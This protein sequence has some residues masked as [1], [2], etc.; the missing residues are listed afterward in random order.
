[1][2]PAHPRLIVDYGLLAYIGAIADVSSHD[3][4]GTVVALG[5]EREFELTLPDRTGP[6]RAAVVPPSVPRSVDGGGATMAVC[7]VDPDLCVSMP[8][9]AG[10][11]LT[12]AQQLAG[13]QDLALWPAFRRA[14]GLAARSSFA[15]HR[16]AAVA[17]QIRASPEAPPRIEELAASAALSPSR[18][19]H[20]FVEHIGCPIRSY[21]VW[22]RFRAVA[23]AFG[24]GE[25]IT[26][27]AQTGGFY[28]SAQFARMFRHSFG[29]APSAVL[30]RH[31]RVQVVGD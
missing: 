10:A 16:I 30:T 12:L 29:L 31:L 24:R 26:A 21:R 13:A 15:D 23:L 20:L 2:V 7:V 3:C 22:C 18:L 5:L 9:A 19:E 17:E 14:L 11:P 8:S 25:N 28:D 27:A 1:M 6:V 4:A